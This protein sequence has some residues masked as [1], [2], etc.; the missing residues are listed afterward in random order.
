LVLHSA[1]DHRVRQCDATPQIDQLF[2]APSS[3]RVVSQNRFPDDCSCLLR[4][5]AMPQRLPR[6]LPPFP[7]S[8]ICLYPHGLLRIV[9]LVLFVIRCILNRMLVLA[10]RQQLTTLAYIS[11]LAHSRNA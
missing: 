9:R 4:S 2:S 5:L 10:R 11:R 8:P 6:F 7:V 3:L 1:A